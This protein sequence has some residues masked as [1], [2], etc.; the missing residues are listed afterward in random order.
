V[1]LRLYFVTLTGTGTPS[2]AFRLVARQGSQFDGCDAR[3]DQ[4]LQAGEFALLLDGTASDHT[5]MLGSAG[6]TYLPC[7]DAGGALV[8]PLGTIASISAANRTTIQTL[9]EGRHIPVA[10]VTGATLV[11]TLWRFIEVRAVLRQLLTTDDWT[12]LLD[13]LV[14]AMN[15]QKRSNIA[16]KLQAA[17]FD[18]SGIQGSDTIRQAIFKIAVQAVRMSR[19][20]AD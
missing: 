16:A 20:G 3:P 2:D 7:E 19:T 4:A 12:E 10:W 18:T 9:C 6:V 8:G 14:S 5:T 15:A 1:A 17:G 11:K 13:S